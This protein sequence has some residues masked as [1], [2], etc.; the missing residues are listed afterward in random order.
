[1]RAD[2]VRATLPYETAALVKGAER[3]RR[4]CPNV[5]AA[6]IAGVDQLIME[7]ALRLHLC[8]SDT[9]VSERDKRYARDVLPLVVA[10][11]ATN[12][13][14]MSAKA[15]KEYEMLPDDFIFP[16]K[17]KIRDV[18]DELIQKRKQVTQNCS[19]IGH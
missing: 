2:Y 5:A 11:I 9:R 15:R 13:V 10:Y 8:L 3:I 7:H 18:L 1:M 19:S 4:D 12:N 6:T 14:G 17:I 16:R